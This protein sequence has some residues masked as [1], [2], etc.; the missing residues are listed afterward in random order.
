M[1]PIYLHPEIHT[2]S[3]ILETNVLKV[4]F[5]LPSALEYKLEICIEFRARTLSHNLPSHLRVKILMHFV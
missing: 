3:Y 2:L 5:L 1:S 4:C